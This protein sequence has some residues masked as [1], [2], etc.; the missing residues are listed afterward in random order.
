MGATATGR[1]SESEFESRIPTDW[2]SAYKIL[3]GLRL[4]RCYALQDRCLL[5][6]LPSS[7]LRRVNRCG[8]VKP[9]AVLLAYSQRTCSRE[10]CIPAIHSNPAKGDEWQRQDFFLFCTKL[11]IWAYGI[12]KHKD[13]TLR[14]GASDLRNSGTPDVFAV[15]R[16][17]FH[18]R[19]RLW[20][21]PLMRRNRQADREALPPS[22]HP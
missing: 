14:N 20:S 13:Q 17:A 5:A 3:I 10:S 12:R 18:S 1:L 6:Q 16:R 19:G 2:L 11:L 8:M 9:C 15:Y 22:K 4:L 21:S 7:A